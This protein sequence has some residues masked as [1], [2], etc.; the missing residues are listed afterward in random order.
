MKDLKQV[1]KQILLEIPSTRNSRM[2]LYWEVLRKKG[3]VFNDEYGNEHLEMSKDDFM[4]NNSES[5]RRCSQA[6]QRTDLLTGDKLI[7]PAEEIKKVR[8]K[9]S[10]EKGYNYIQGRE[11]VFNPT[12]QTYVQV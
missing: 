10:H 2:L 5:V 7:Q 11:Y 3:F 12:T 4:K 8:V 1:I 6:L 9:M